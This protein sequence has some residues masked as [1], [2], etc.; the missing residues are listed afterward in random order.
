MVHGQQPISFGWQMV[1]ID[2]NEMSRFSLGIHL[3]SHFRAH[4][5]EGPL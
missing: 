5:K 1:G 3:F 2:R 4:D